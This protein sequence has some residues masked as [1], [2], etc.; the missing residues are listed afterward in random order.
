MA[1]SM[2][3]FQ[4][5]GLMPLED[6]MEISSDHGRAHES[7]IDIDIDLPTPRPQHGEDYDDVLVDAADDSAEELNDDVMLDENENMDDDR[8][9]QEDGLNAD[10]QLPGV[11]G[12]AITTSQVYAGVQP[13]QVHVQD[14]APHFDAPGLPRQASADTEI[15]EL[16][17]QADSNGDGSAHV[18]LQVSADRDDRDDLD[19]TQADVES[20]DPEHLQSLDASNVDVLTASPEGKD[21]GSL[22]RDHEIAN[23]AAEPQRSYE[24]GPHSNGQ[25]RDQETLRAPHAEDSNGISGADGFVQYNEHSSAYRQ[26]FA[27]RSITVDYQGSKIS[28]FPPKGQNASKTYFLENEGLVNGSIRDLLGA[29]RNV[30]G[31]SISDE[32]ELEVHIAALD[33][34]IGEVSSIESSSCGSSC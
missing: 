12:E 21:Q 13:Y 4:Q 32:E 24:H 30:L 22:S 34:C 20:K 15:N 2:A 27:D 31:E 33:L 9:M 17:G 25:L 16:R 1:S 18:E 11:Y 26:S 14:D 10:E 3:T 6:D 7:D 29:C 28:L 5:L 23:L 19:P 8:D